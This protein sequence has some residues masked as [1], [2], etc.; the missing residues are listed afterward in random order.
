MR[1]DFYMIQENRHFLPAFVIAGILVI[2]MTVKAETPQKISERLMSNYQAMT[3]RDILVS[4][5]PKYLNFY[6]GPVRLEQ[7][8]LV[9]LENTEYTAIAV[10]ELNSRIAELG[11]RRLAVVPNVI[12]GKYNLIID[13]VFLKEKLSVQGYR[14]IREKQGLRL[15]GADRTGLLYAAVTARGLFSKDKDGVIFHTAEVTDWPDIIDR[16]VNG[17]ERTQYRELYRE[18][19]ERLFNASVPWI[20]N[21]FRHKI[22]TVGHHTWTPFQDCFSPF[23]Q[24][25]DVPP[26]YLRSIR[27]LN[28]YMDTLG[29]KRSV[30]MSIKLGTVAQNGKNPAVKDLMHVPWH[31]FYFSWGRPDLQ[32]IA[33]QKML[34]WAKAAGIN[35]ITLHP[36]DSGDII[37]PELWS[38]RDAASRKLY[39]LDTDRAKG[40]ADQLALYRKVF[41]G[42]GVKL[43][44][45]PYPYFGA[46]ATREGVARILNVKVDS[47]LAEE[48]LNKNLQWGRDFNK[49]IP[50]D[51]MLVVREGT[52]KEVEA[53]AGMFSGHRFKIYFETSVM[54]FLHDDHP[55][56]SPYLATVQTFQP[57]ADEVGRENSPQYYE[58]FIPITAE[59]MWNVY[60]PHYTDWKS[61]LDTD[62]GRLPFMSEYT[63]K[64]TWGPEIGKIVSPA[65]STGLSLQYLLRPEAVDRAMN[66]KE[67]LLFCEQA[68]RKL[69][70][71]IQV[72]DEAQLRLDVAG[73][74]GHY[75]IGYPAPQ[76]FNQYRVI[77]YGSRI[78]IDGRYA[79]LRMMKAIKAGKMA[80][81]SAI[82]EEA[83]ASLRKSAVE[84]ERLTRRYKA[85]ELLMP[86]D[87]I[88]N[89]V[90]LFEQ[91]MRPDVNKEIKSILTLEK[92]KQKIFAETNAPVWL[93]Q[94][95]Q[96]PLPYCYA[97]API[98]LDGDVAEPVWKKA[99]PIEHFVNHSAFRLMNAPIEVRVLYDA[100]NLYVSGI[101]ERPGLQNCKE[102][103]TCGSECFQVFLPVQDG[104][105][106]QLIIFPNGKI[107]SHAGTF[108]PNS[109]KVNISAA[110]TE[111]VC[112]TAVN[113]GQWSFELKIPFSELGGKPDKA[114][115]AYETA[116]GKDELPGI[117]Y[118]TAFTD[119]NSF[120]NQKYFRK[121]VD[122]TAAVQ[123]ASCV[124]LSLASSAEMTNV[125]HASG[126]GSMVTFKPVIECRRP[127]KE[128]KVNA[129]IL[130]VNGRLLKKTAV[131]A[132]HFIPALHTPETISILTDTIQKAVIIRITAQYLLE[133]R[134]C[135][136]TAYFPAGKINADS[137]RKV[138]PEL[139][140]TIS[141]MAWHPRRT[142]LKQGSIEF[143]IRFVGAER[144]PRTV[145]HA[146]TVNY[147]YPGT[148]NNNSI[149]ASLY[150]R[151]L[152]V[153]VWNRQFVRRSLGVLLKS[154][155]WQKIHIE[156][157]AEKND[158]YLAVTVDGKKHTIPASDPQLRKKMTDDFT[159]TDFVQ[160][161][162][163]NTSYEPAYVQLKDM[164]FNGTV[165]TEKDLYAGC[166]GPCKIVFP[167][168]VHF[169]YK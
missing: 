8:A 9:V 28:M 116:P 31:N 151:F 52:K 11:G 109:G 102:A 154:D 101:A 124:S 19:P 47:P 91:A 123:P 79:R 150:G 147:R 12:S 10:D 168:A 159:E 90:Y 81:A 138:C 93:R 38:M 99:V 143:N 87:R 73:G 46:T 22:N 17:S 144:R 75:G 140:D 86:L 43:V 34:N 30:T 42:S 126:T 97:N 64:A 59:Y 1:K 92:Q 72:F 169:N 58:P 145:F 156:W 130:D 6:R 98:T 132:E 155:Q 111:A 67:P 29:I 4:P 114:L 162:A 137:F 49:L 40:D 167:A 94:S 104:T 84:F 96:E 152:T 139:P 158:C 135:I 71:A 37:D 2:S 119:G 56:L 153:S 120:F 74:F 110:E 157:K 36:V 7:M 32:T 48:Y 21:L 16:R 95:F 26:K 161:N 122:R 131:A 55:L 106:R 165:V 146:S 44:W 5:I 117:Y 77:F 69:Y 61:K 39:P 164:I 160:F 51:T 113:A 41:A 134:T 128:L 25:P 103:K 121:L 82:A 141:F 83:V 107:L 24:T 35:V 70:A 60:A 88:T 118:A 57:Y 125:L 127:V 53:F 129:E 62:P 78:F 66:I 115:F 3:A 100:G 136:A 14:L 89:T 85:E 166:A 133:G 33:A 45:C 148:A 20:K 68:R 23:R 80:E 105:T 112:R 163:L 142:D 63:C 27:E 76:A 13:S 65:F 50:A 15:A 54:R 18:E 108:F 149:Q